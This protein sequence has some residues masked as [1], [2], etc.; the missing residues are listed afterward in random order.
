M[1]AAGGAAGRQSR[2]AL[3]A[4]AAIDLL[5]PLSALNCCKRAPISAQ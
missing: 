2:S 5:C 4:K 3:V 1:A